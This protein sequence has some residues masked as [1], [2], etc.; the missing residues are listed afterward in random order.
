MMRRVGILVAA[1]SIG[2][3]VAAPAMANVHVSRGQTVSEIRVIGQDVTVDGVAHGPVIVIGGN[4]TVGPHGRVTN[5]TVIFGAVHAAPGSQFLGD[6]FQFGGPMPEL[7]GWLLALVLML[8]YATRTGLYG[9]AIWLGRRLARTRYQRA[10]LE[11][12]RERPGRTVTAGILA[13]V[14]LLAVSAISLLTI[15]GILV[16]F[17]IWALLLVAL[18]VGLAVVSEP[19]AELRLNRGV[20]LVAAIPVIGDALL[21]LAMAIGVGLL[22]RRLAARRSP[23]PALAG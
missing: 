10:L 23:Q 17:I 5:V 1:L 6:V 2:L 13:S 20:Y 22:L 9:L 19:L 21:A 18:I 3:A 15:G 14:G 12:A 11:L 7:N 16:A 4:L 8:V